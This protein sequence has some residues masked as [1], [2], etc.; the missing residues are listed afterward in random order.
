MVADFKL[1]FLNYS[2]GWT[3]FQV[4]RSHFIYFS[5]SVNC[6]YLL[7]S[8]GFLNSYLNSAKKLQWVEMFGVGVRGEEKRAGRNWG[9]GLVGHPGPQEQH[10]LLALT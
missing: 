1:H 5:S 8:N 4:F 10:I 7:F 3:S 6:L 2:Y 9:T